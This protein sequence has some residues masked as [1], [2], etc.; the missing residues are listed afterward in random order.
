MDQLDTN[1]NQIANG[2]Q[3]N[4]RGNRSSIKTDKSLQNSIPQ[5]KHAR[6]VDDPANTFC[7]QFSVELLP[8]QG[9]NGSF[10]QV[11]TAGPGPSLTASANNDLL[12]QSQ[13]QHKKERLAQH[14]QIHENNSFGID[15]YAPIKEDTSVEA[16]AKIADLQQQL[17]KMKSDKDVLEITVK[18]LKTELDS[19]SNLVRR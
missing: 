12:M 11:N 9:P 13:S 4:F 19:K 18:H 1:S 17:V 6:F 16:K 8:S 14:Q 5:Q 3:H 2:L 15:F 7:D 10:Y